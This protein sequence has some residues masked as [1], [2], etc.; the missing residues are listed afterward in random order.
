MAVSMAASHTQLSRA[1]ALRESLEASE[2]LAREANQVL[3]GYST[4]L[5]SLIESVEHVAT[6][7]QVDAA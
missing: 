4:H 3:E 7:A 1:A 6:R 5:D 2:Q